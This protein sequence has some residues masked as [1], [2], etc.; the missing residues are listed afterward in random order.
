[1]KLKTVT[2]FVVLLLVSSCYS[3]GYHST[4]IMSEVVPES[5]EGS[6]L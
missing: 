4:Y 2:L 5:Q 6:S 1:M 3:N